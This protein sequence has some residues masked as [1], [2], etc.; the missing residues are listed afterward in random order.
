ML[1]SLVCC[2]ERHVEIKE[3]I[4]WFSV[5]TF[6]AK[7]ISSRVKGF[8]PILVPRVLMNRLVMV[9]E[10]VASKAQTGF[11]PITEN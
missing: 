6:I 7:V 2:V 5:V 8:K 3:E 1:M 10:S 11:I 4:M 9:I